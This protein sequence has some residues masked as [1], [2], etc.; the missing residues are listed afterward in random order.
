MLGGCRLRTLHEQEGLP[1]CLAPCG[2][3][4]RTAGTQETTASLLWRQLD[5]LHQ[6]REVGWDVLCAHHG[7]KAKI[8]QPAWTTLQHVWACCALS[9]HAAACDMVLPVGLRNFFLQK[10][11]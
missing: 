4:T 6:G 5:I 1:F 3:R 7:L 10:M 8:P 2:E 11:T 9:R